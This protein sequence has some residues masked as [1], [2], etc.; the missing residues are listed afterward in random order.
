MTHDCGRSIA[1]VLKEIDELK[2]ENERLNSLKRAIDS[3]RTGGA[4]FK[5]EH[6]SA[7]VRIGPGNVLAQFGIS[8]IDG[9]RIEVESGIKILGFDEDGNTN[10]E[11]EVDGPL[12]YFHKDDHSMFGSKAVIDDDEDDWWGDDDD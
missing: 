11:I 1:S 4:K 9:I 5:E 3:I 6:G 8:E 12:V 2:A 7:E 10:E